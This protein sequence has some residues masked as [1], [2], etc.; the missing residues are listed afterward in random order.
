MSVH[1]IL[2]K[3]EQ[4]TAVDRAASALAGAVR[5]ALRGR[6]L[7][8]VLRG[9]WLGHPVHPLLVTVPI[10][11]WMSAA[12]LDLCGERVAARQ[13]VATGLVAS[14]PTVLAGLADFGELTTEQRRVGVLHASVNT[15]A[16]VLFLRSYACR[17]QGRHAAGT[18]WS[19]LGLLVLSAGGALGGHLSYAQGAGV[20]R[21]E[22]VDD[23]R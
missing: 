18:A 17:R 19:T 8:R 1:G 2:D 10:G 23:T 16:S 3:S 6:G 20:H 12:V 4:V 9:A 11:A 5:R 15:A 13:L 14:A 7:D 21:W 22:R